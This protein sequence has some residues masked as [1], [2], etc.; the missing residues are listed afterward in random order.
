MNQEKEGNFLVFHSFPQPIIIIYYIL[1]Y[2][3]III[4]QCG[5]VGTMMNS[6][7]ARE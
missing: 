4:M 5:N 2:I 3:Y 6:G 1:L 7:F